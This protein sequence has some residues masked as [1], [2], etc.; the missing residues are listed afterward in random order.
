MKTLGYYNGSFAE[1]EEMK[2]PMLDRGCY[3]GDGVYEATFARN[4]KIYALDEHVDRMYRSA[5]MVDINIP[6][7]KEEMKAILNDMMSK[8]DSGDQFVYWQVT[9]GTA[10]RNHLYSHDMQ[11]NLWI[12]LRPGGI[13]DIFKKIKLITLEDTRYY[14]CN[15]KTLNLI[16]SVIAAE[17]AND[18]GCKESVLHRGERVTECAHANVH[19]IK[20][21]VFRTAPTDCLILPGIAR[22]H[23]IKAAHKLGIPVDETAFTLDEMMDADEVFVSSST[24]LC[25]VADEIDGKSVGGKATEIITALQNEILN[26]YL[27]A[28]EKD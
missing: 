4:Y 26:N 18:A 6:Q 8:M 9:R 12:M 10:P 7:T 19:I 23:L 28:T 13:P 22:A 24:S 15:I 25:M 27:N 5:A 14:H 21:G 3:F 20:D 1:I 2:I 16:P 17:K 11:G